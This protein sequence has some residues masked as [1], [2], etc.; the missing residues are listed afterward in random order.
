MAKKDRQ[1]K[2][3]ERKDIRDTKKD[4]KL[5]EKISS[6]TGK[7][8]I[9][10]DNLPAGPMTEASKQQ[11]TQAVT[12]GATKDV[13]DSATGFSKAYATPKYLDRPELKE[14]QLKK[15]ARREK[16]A[17]IWDAIGA[18]GRGL[19]G[20]EI[21]TS[22]FKSAQI[23]QGRED[24]YTEFRDISKANKATAQKWEGNYR[25]DLIDFLDQKLQD[26]GTSE[27]EKIK[28]QQALAQ[29][30]KT[31]AETKYVKNKPYS[32]AST[33]TKPTYTH[34]SEEGN[35]QMTNQKNPYT[36]LYY[37]MSGNSPA[38]INAFAKISDFPLNK[39]GGLAR[40]LSD[41]DVERLSNDLLSKAFDIQV[42]DNGNQ[43][44]IPKPGKEN[45]LQNL[46]SSISASE[47]AQEKIS[48]L[49]TEMKNEIYNAEGSTFLGMGTSKESVIN[50][51]KEKY[52]PLISQAQAELD[53]S[54]SKV[55]SMF[56]G[57]NTQDPWEL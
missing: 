18:V 48:Q 21:D 38:L 12:E 9:D 14:E 15:E 41:S 32:T 35:W 30:E 42:D 45:L 11:I 49:E 34:Q 7:H 8:G 10:L 52:K 16:K 20:K 56:S 44:A 33:K 40:S 46:S 47:Q 24:Q 3:A 13:V 2:R 4:I 57:D 51:I 1:E 31:K 5:E 17:R 27:M 39:E 29:L 19:Q 37:K 22:K 43:V 28:Y 55:K 36:D 53:T 6:E 26:K 25:N 54:E 23:R 50:T